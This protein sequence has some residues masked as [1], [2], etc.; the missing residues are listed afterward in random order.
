METTIYTAG[1]NGARVLAVNAQTSDTSVNDVALYVQVGG[2][3]TAYPL[4]AVAVT[5]LAG[6]NA[7]PPTAAISLLAAAQIPTL[8]ADGSLQLGA[9]D[10]LQAAVLAAVTAAKTLTIFV[11]AIDY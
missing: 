6:L 2:S 10:T 3:G 4:G 9:G 8:L 7:N 1:S 11:Q 5:A